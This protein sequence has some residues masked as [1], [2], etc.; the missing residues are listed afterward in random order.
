MDI[1]ISIFTN[2]LF[3]LLFNLLCDIVAGWKKRTE[4]VIKAIENIALTKKE[5]PTAY[6]QSTRNCTATKSALPGISHVSE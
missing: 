3:H 2:L 4:K 1:I 5:L 6:S